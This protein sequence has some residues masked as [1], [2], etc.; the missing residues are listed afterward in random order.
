MKKLFSILLAAICLVALAVPVFA[1]RGHYHTSTSRE[2]SYIGLDA[3]K[4][5]AF[6]DAGESSSSVTLLSTATYTNQGVRVYKVVFLTGDKKH[7]YEINATT[8]GVYSHYTN[9]R[10]NGSTNPR[11][12]DNS[13]CDDT[14][15]GEYLDKATVK[16][17]VLEHAGVSEADLTEYECELEGKKGR[18]VYEIEFELGEIEYEYLV[19]AGTGEIIEWEID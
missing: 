18:L 8:G 13:G 1:G 14:W 11:P 12:S 16:A 15:S 2:T 7:V 4:A 19:N 9:P 10:N 5:A 3:A 17:I 6:A